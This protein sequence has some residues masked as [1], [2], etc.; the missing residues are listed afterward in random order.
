[1]AAKNTIKN[2]I[3]KILSKV[4]NGLHS[5]EYWKPVH[6][7]FKSLEQAGYHVSIESSEYRHENGVMVDKKWLYNVSAE[8]YVFYGVLTAHGAGTVKDPLSKYDISA[9][10]S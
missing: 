10:V 9:Y 2:R 1:M 3:N 5:D 6:E 8:G 7:A 4:T